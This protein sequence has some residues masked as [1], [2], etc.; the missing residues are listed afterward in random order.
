MIRALLAPAPHPDFAHMET[1]LRWDAPLPSGVVAQCSA[2]I[3]REAQVARLRG[4]AQPVTW[5][6]QRNAQPAMQGVA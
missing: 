4:E 1:V 3:G 2:D 6:W 5:P